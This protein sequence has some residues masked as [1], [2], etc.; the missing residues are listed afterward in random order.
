MLF[1]KKKRKRTKISVKDLL[2]TFRQIRNTKKK[3]TLKLPQIVSGK[4]T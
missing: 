4:S 2:L 1:W 3:K